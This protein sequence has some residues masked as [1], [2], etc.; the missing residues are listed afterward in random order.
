MPEQIVIADTSCFIILTKVNELELLRQV[1]GQVKTTVD[2]AIEF[3]EVLH[4]WVIVNMVADSERQQALE[5]QIDRG[6]ASAIALALESPNSTVILDDYKARQVAKGLGIK[7]TG[8]IGII[9]RAKH[10]GIILSIKPIFRKN[11]RDELP[12]FQRNRIAGSEKC[13]RMAFFF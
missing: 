3:G 5:R 4:D 1:Y 11:K 12:S 9:M 8:T 2:I 6:E 13:R 7:F 10:K